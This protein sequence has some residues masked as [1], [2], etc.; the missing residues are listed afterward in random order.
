MMSFLGFVWIVFFSFFTSL[1]CLSVS[2]LGGAHLLGTCDEPEEMSPA[3]GDLVFSS[4]QRCGHG[5]T[6]AST[7]RKRSVRSLSPH[8]QGFQCSVLM[9]CGYDAGLHQRFR[10]TGSLSSRV[11]LDGE[12]TKEMRHRWQM[13]DKEGLMTS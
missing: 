1:L 2:T 5:G 10:V 11:L 7:R 8:T 3:F 9:L 4:V 13:W 12:N 6:N